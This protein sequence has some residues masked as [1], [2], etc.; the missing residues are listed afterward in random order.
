MA[1]GPASIVGDTAQVAA[2]RIQREI[3]ESK[4][5]KESREELGTPVGDVQR[6]V[7]TTASDVEGNVLKEPDAAKALKGVLKY[8]QQ[9]CL[10]HVVTNFMSSRFLLLFGLSITGMYLLAKFKG[11]AFR[12]ARSLRSLFQLRLGRRRLGLSQLKQQEQGAVQADFPAP[13]SSLVYYFE[14]MIAHAGENAYIGLGY[15]HSGYPE[16]RHVG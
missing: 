7:T 1:D 14:I 2:S 9:Q 12:V 13:P 16:T 6:V 8:L 11:L 15:A 4:Q 10:Q 3:N 5:R